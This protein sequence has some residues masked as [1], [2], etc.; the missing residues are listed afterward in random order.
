MVKIGA[1]PDSL[2]RNNTQGS[3][4]NCGKPV[5]EGI[6]IF[7]AIAA[8]PSR[9]QGSRSGLPARIIQPHFR[10]L[11]GEIQDGISVHVVTGRVA[12]VCTH[13]QVAKAAVLENGPVV[14]FFA[15]FGVLGRSGFT[16][17]A[18]GHATEPGDL[19][20]FCDQESLI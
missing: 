20:H 13:I 15:H 17:Q 12:G 19:R 16:A 3:I 10:A 4:A 2:H 8:H 1:R 7:V 14:R 6:T 5:Q 18:D 9:L 11:N